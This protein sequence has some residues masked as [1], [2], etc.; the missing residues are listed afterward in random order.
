MIRTVYQSTEWMVWLVCSET[1]LIACSWRI[2]PRWKMNSHQK[3]L[4]ST[5][6]III[7]CVLYLDHVQL[8]L[9]VEVSRWLPQQLTRTILQEF[10]CDQIYWNNCIKKL[11]FFSVNRTRQAKLNL[12]S[13][14]YASKLLLIESSF[15]MTSITKRF[16]HWR[17]SW[18]K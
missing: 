5:L 11:V 14:R 6:K 1:F 12:M 4:H 13:P 16:L 10:F 3:S 15:L 9:T 17:L 7:L 18:A 8:Y 2:V